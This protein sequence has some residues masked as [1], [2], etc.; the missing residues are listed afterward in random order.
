MGR[1]LSVDPLA[2]KYPGAS[3][4][5]YCFN[6]PVWLIDPDGRWPWIANVAIGSPHTLAEIR[7]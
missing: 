1:R 2:D 5:N 6:N 4:F 3:P 7:R